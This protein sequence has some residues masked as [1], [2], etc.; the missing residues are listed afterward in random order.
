MSQEIP[1]LARC[2]AD[3]DN[4]EKLHQAARRG[5][6][7][8]VRRLVGSGIPLGLPNKF[9]CTALHLAARNGHTMTVKELGP[10]SNLS[11]GWHGKLPLHLAVAGGH[12]DTILALLEAAKSQNIIHYV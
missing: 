4:M 10:K 7:D 11:A 3:D 1:K 6:T 12:K 5:Q 2:K 9:G 8:L